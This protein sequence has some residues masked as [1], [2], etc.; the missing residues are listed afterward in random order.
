M[1]GKFEQAAARFAEACAV[2]PEAFDAWYLLGM[3]Y[4]RLG[5][6][7]RARR[8][9]LEC[10]EA[11]N[12]WVRVHPE[13]TRAW[14][15]GASVLAEVGEPERAAQWVE[16]AMTVDPDEPIIQYNSACVYVGLRRPDDA[17]RC[18][19]AA[20]RQGGVLKSWAL[21]DPDL[22]PLRDDPRF[23]EILDRAV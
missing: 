11:V 20:L 10:I 16:R 22:D 12:R 6:M 8:A 17:I 5:E 19:E 18:L 3:C 4:R 14:T 2:V 23:K 1:Q 15:M 9:D 7:E 21:N 13:D